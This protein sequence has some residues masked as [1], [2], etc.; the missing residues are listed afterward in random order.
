MR[1]LNR[2]S[3]SA[4]IGRTGHCVGLVVNAISNV[5][6]IA[7]QFFPKSDDLCCLGPRDTT[8]SVKRA[9]SRSCAVSL[10]LAVDPC[11]IFND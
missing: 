7:T 9:K 2:V 11:C 1:F 6:A 3:Y 8:P 5:R 4:G 10:K